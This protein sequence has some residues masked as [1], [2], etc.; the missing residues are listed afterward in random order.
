MLCCIVYYSIGFVW[1][2]KNIAAPVSRSIFLFSRQ[3]TAFVRAGGD[4][5]IL[6]GVLGWLHAC[7]MNLHLLILLK[8][9]YVA[10][11]ESLI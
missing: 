3:N 8:V 1:F 10:F 9:T 5:E 7:D 6:I 4:L 2:F 11:E